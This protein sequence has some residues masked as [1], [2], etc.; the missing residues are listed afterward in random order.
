MRVAGYVRVSTQEQTEGYSIPEQQDRLAAY[1]K[2]K[3]WQLVR[4]YTDGGYSGAKLD[5]PAL[6]ELIKD[7]LKYDMILVYKLD[8]LS[9][10]QK[11]TLYLIEDVFKANKVDFAS[12]QENFDTS[13]PFGMAMIGIL[14]VFAQ[15]ERE[16]IRERMQ[17]G[18]IGK[19]K[20]GRW[21]FSGHA[22][23]GYDY[24]KGNGGK[25]V[26]NDYEAEQI[27]KIFEMYL[28]GQSMRQISLY[29]H[30]HYTNKYG[31]WDS[32]TNI[33]QTIDNPLY[34]GKMR[35]RGQIYDGQHEAIIT[36]ETW[37]AA[38]AM[39]Q[40]NSDRNIG[41]QSHM[42]TGLIYCAECGGKMGYK[43][44]RIKGGKTYEYYA[45]RNHLQQYKTIDGAKHCDAPAWRC[46]A[47][48]DAVLEQVK[49]IKTISRQRKEKPN[50]RRQIAEIEKQIHRA[51]MLYLIDGI[52]FDSIK[53][54][55]D[56]LNRRKEYLKNE[57]A[58]RRAGEVA[59]KAAEEAIA[60]IPDIL[61]SDDL[62]AKIRLLN[63]IIDR[64][65]VGKDY[66]AVYLLF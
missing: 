2:A 23:I 13:T 34:C 52:D 31:S 37:Q 51:T 61:S 55:I 47:L 49:Q 32:L 20:E 56:E 18:K 63:A 38:Q 3:G 27:R 22:P 59:R 35:S 17:M 7:C 21:S 1:C 4:V 65:E 48:E 15:L 53:N 8:R 26:V 58:S 14:S 30:S 43:A 40:K 11:D 62:D 19:A 44:H 50:N 41:R 54:T 12:M 36:E 25:L 60:S 64:I 24:I 29:M 66:V 42:L 5:R 33:R 9:R 57:D 39:R 6:Q 28:A 45:C 10:S 46:E 16:Q